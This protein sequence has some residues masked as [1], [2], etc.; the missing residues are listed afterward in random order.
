MSSWLDSHY[1][2]CKQA[3]TLTGCVLKVPSKGRIV[4]LLVLV[5]VLESN[6]P[7]ED[8]DEDEDEI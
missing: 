8:E 1:V 3:W 7:A 2:A 5:V 4:L 6:P